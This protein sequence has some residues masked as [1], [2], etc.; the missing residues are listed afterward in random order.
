M[1][2]KS[3]E[4]QHQLGVRK[5]GKLEGKVFLMAGLDA[6][7]GWEVVDNGSSGGTAAINQLHRDGMR[8]GKRVQVVFVE[9][10]GFR[11]AVR[12]AKVNQRPDKYG[13]VMGKKQVE[14]H[15][16]VAGLK[17]GVLGPTLFSH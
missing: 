1:A 10:G 5:G 11:E 12:G 17:I 7:V 13:W 14:Y 4:A 3:G 9:K 6:K 8:V 16:E 2:G 15:G